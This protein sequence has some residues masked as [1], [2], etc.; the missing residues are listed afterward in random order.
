MTTTAGRPAVDVFPPGFLR[1]GCAICGRLGRGQYDH[2][3]DYWKIESDTGLWFPGD[4]AGRYVAVPAVHP[5]DI[6]GEDFAQHKVAAMYPWLA[7]FA[8]AVATERQ[9]A[10]YDLHLSVR[11]G[12]PYA[13]IVPRESARGEAFGWLARTDLGP[14]RKSG[15]TCWGLRPGST[16]NG[17]ANLAWFAA[18]LGAVIAFAVTLSGLS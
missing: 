10:P 15:R 13:E 18:L 9:M 12:H 17:L 8:G 16:A 11:E 6:R 5:S 1:G 3:G 14:A 7:A 4:R 2:A